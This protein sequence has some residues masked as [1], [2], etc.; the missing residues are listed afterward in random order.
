MT[1]NGHYSGSSH[2]VVWQQELAY[3]LAE[4]YD[5]F[6]FHAVAPVPRAVDKDHT[7]IAA[8]HSLAWAPS[9]EILMRLVVQYISQILRRASIHSR[10]TRVLAGTDHIHTFNAPT[11]TVCLA[12]AGLEDHVLIFHL[13]LL[14]ESSEVSLCFAE[15]TRVVHRDEALNL[16]FHGDEHGSVLE[17]VRSC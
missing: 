9:L 8:A 7:R 2:E 5:F 12:A 1:V 3:V 10:F 15:S 4:F 14:L 16:G 13:S 17:S 11:Q 6:I